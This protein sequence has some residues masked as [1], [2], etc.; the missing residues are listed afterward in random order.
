MDPS[1]NL[2]RLRSPV[3][4]YIQIFHGTSKK[5]GRN[6]RPN[7]RKGLALHTYS[8]STLDA[9]IRRLGMGSE[10]L[11]Q[12]WTHGPCF[13]PPLA[14]SLPMVLFR[15]VGTTDQPRSFNS[16]LLGCCGRGLP[17][18]PTHKVGDPF[19]VATA[20]IIRRLSLSLS[21]SLSLF[22]FLF[23]ELI[24]LPF[25]V[26]RLVLDEHAGFAASP[27]GIASLAR[28]RRFD[29]PRMPHSTMGSGG[30]GIL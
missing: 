26:L 18:N 25:H 4:E 9:A 30:F 3:R 2:A 15:G 7:V 28:T 21:I 27:P 6:I 11:S 20:S 22:L 8:T 1:D 29:I 23:L 19:V 5:G 17:R 10:F 12:Q 13:P 24:T 16:A 14:A